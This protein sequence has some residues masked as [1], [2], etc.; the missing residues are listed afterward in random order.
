MHQI[1]EEYI[2]QR[3]GVRVRVH[4]NAH[5][6]DPWKFKLAYSIAKRWLDENSN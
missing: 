3:K 2:Y 6:Q 5:I 4:P 1:I